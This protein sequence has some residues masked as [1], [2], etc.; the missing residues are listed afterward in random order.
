MPTLIAVAGGV[1]SVLYYLRPLP[2]LFA[3]LRGEGDAADVPASPGLVPG[4]ILAPVAVWR[5]GDAFPA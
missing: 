2:D 4:V 5:L 3:A 1:F